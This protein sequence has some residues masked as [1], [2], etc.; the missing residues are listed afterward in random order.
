MV[1]PSAKKMA[2]ACNVFMNTVRGAL[3]T[4]EAELVESG[5]DEKKVQSALEEVRSLLRPI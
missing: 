4:A 1:S 5:I 2:D 3:A